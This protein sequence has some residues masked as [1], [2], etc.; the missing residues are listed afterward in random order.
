MHSQ[1]ARARKSARTGV[2]ASIAAFAL[3]WCLPASGQD[4]PGLTLDA[5]LDIAVQ[6]APMVMA[7]RA[8]AEGAAADRVSAGEL[9]DPRLFVGVDNLPITGEDR[10]SLTDD[11]M[12][13]SKIGWMQEVPNRDKRKARAEAAQALGDREQALLA[14]ERQAVRRLAALAWLQR[15][16][17]E[18]RIA[19][20]AGL[21][22]ENRL[23]RDTV[24]ARVAAG[25]ALPAEST[26]ARQEA[27]E[28]A[29]RRDELQ[30]EREQAQAA[31]ARWVEPAADA[32]L[33]GEPSIPTIDP[34]HL[35][36]N[37]ARHVEL[38]A[39]EPNARIAAA[40]AREAQAGKKGDWA[41]EVSYAKRGS[42]FSDMVSV[43]FSF[44][45]PLFA[46]KRRDPRILAK[47]KEM[48]RIE[49]ERQ[50]M[51]RQHRQEIEGELAEQ[52]EWV[53][54]LTRLR[55]TALP[56]ADERIRLLM[57]SYRA[58]RA[59]LGSVLAARRDRAETQLKA[60]QAEAQLAAVRAQLAYL[61]TEHRP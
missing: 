27:A 57:A 38:A 50:E 31:L 60:I 43:Q 61:F 44:D 52:E 47:H 3:W 15:Y 20:F 37:I 11:F 42:E 40:E 6:Q 53:R 49:A 54:R 5:A 59:D 56:L 1:L 29:D 58:G 21:E 55:E 34:G 17:A 18:K 10:F 8:S 7:R 12:T 51:L 36:D 41:W 48:E 39:F 33:A 46:A 13:M 32:A 24:N 2:C 28:L 9:P 26:M 35:R 22:R 19:L 4:K 45:L 16:Y 23:L 30:R 14:A 25:R